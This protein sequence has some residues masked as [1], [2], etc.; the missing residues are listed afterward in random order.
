M[1]LTSPPSWPHARLPESHAALHRN[2]PHREAYLD[3]VLDALQ[4]RYLFPVSGR[5]L[6]VD[7][8]EGVAEMGL[9]PGG[10]RHEF[11]GRIPDGPPLRT[12]HPRLVPHPPGSAFLSGAG[13]GSGAAAS[14]NGGAAGL[15]AD[16]LLDVPAQAVPAG[17]NCVLARISARRPS[18]A[19]LASPGIQPRVACRRRR[20]TGIAA[21][22]DTPLVL[23]RETDR[24]L[25]HLQARVTDVRRISQEILCGQRIVTPIRGDVTGVGNPLIQPRPTP[26]NK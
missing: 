14:G 19:R 1:N 11:H 25:S 24:L 26:G 4:R 2:L 16:A 20:A 5:L 12:L 23:A 9:S 7:R 8:G 15:L 18:A 6:L 10:R 3:A 13:D 22:V 17:L 21:E